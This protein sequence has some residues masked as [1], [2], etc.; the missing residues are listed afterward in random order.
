M[1]NYVA[2]CI[3]TLRFR[4]GLKAQGFTRQHLPW[5][6]RETVPYT[7]VTLV[8]LVLIVF[9]QGWIVFTKVSLSSC[10]RLRTYRG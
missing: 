3:I 5:S 10:R 9:T 1:L 6:R 8:M 4:A 7:W 2:M